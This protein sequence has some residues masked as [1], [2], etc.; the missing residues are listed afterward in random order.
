MVTSLLEHLL[1]LPGWLVLA[2]VFAMP[3]LESSAFLG[4][5]FPGEITLILG[6]VVASQGRLPVQAVIVA[7]VIGCVVG[8]SVGYAFG[9]RYGR[10]F[11]DGSLGRWVKPHRLDAAQTYLAERGGRAVFI[12]RFTAA[13]RVLIP[14]L[15]GMSGVPYRTFVLY[16]VASA[17][18]WGTM[19]VLF[20]YVGG[21]N[22]QHVEHLASRIGLLAYVVIA[23]AV[24]GGWWTR[25]RRH[26]RCRRK[27]GATDAAAEAAFSVPSSA[28]R[29]LHRALVVVPTYN[30]ATNVDE[31]LRRV[32]LAEP[33]AQI[34]VVDDGSPD[35][36]ADLV[37]AH[38]DYQ[39]HVHLLERRTKQGLGAAYRAGFAWALARDYDVVVQL[40]ADLSHPP[41]RLPALLRQLDHHGIS[42]GSRYVRGGAVANWPLSRRALSW[43][44]NTYVRLVLRLPVRDATSG[45][46]AF[47]RA[48]LEQIGA[49]DTTSNGY[50]FQIETT[51]RAARQGVALT[52]VPITFTERARGTS[53][54]SAAIATEALYR[55]LLWRWHELTGHSDQDVAGPLDAPLVVGSGAPVR[56]R[57]GDLR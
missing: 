15:A 17:F 32:R 28:S 23:L 7:A 8:D 4:F 3:A 56:Q 2:V 21:A 46:R 36:T 49:L 14:G 41:E 12:G 24:L 9:R 33:A 26:C 40:D 38:P 57:R 30:E 27:T 20:G 1:G 37:R 51:W 52:E 22:W 42:I 6:G 29:T 39:R 53:K 47:S 25:H 54:M 16:N 19:S 35:G 45:Y 31:L 10:R 43:A 13:L 55:V 48:A 18:C 50:C 44:G 5:I 34:L 11:L